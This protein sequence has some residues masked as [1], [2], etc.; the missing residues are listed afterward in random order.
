MRFI[1]CIGLLIYCTQ[2]LAQ[3][4][5]ITLKDT[6]GHPIS[7]A[8]VVLSR[9]EAKKGEKSINK[10]SD[11]N[12]QITYNL[13]GKVVVQ[14][15]HSGFK[16]GVDTVSQKH[17]T[18][19][20]SPLQINLDETV[21]TAQYS[22]EDAKNSLYPVQ[23]INSEKIHQMASNN[24]SEVLAQ[25]LNIRITQDP[26]L[27]SGITLMGLRG[28][29]VKYLVDGV[30]IIGR[31]NGDIDI[32]QVNL[33]DIEKIEVIEGPMS[34]LYGTNAL[35]GVINLITK[36]NQKDLLNI[37]ANAYYESVGTY[38]FDAGLG[39][40]KKNHY[41]GINGGRYFF[42][43]FSLHPD[44]R[45][46]DWN[47]KTQYFANLKYGYQ[48]KRIRFLLSG[49]YFNEKI[50]NKGN[51]RAPF[52]TS[53][54]DD[55][56]KTTRAN[57]ALTVNGDIFKNHYFSQIISYNWYQ[58]K[59]NTYYKDL[60]TL[61][62]TLVGD[63]TQ[64]DTTVFNSIMAR[65][66]VS[67]KADK[68]IFNYQFGYDINVE[69]GSGQRIDNGKKTIGDYAVFGS[70]RA[71]L[72]NHKLIIQPGLRWSYNSA[73]KAPVTPSINFKINPVEHFTIRLAY[74]RGFRAPA[75]KELYFAFYD[76]NH[77]IYGNPDLKAEY[78]NNATINLTYTR[79]FGSHMLNLQANAYFNDI[80]NA[81]ELVRDY[82]NTGGNNTQPYTYQNYANNRVAGGNVK[83][84]YN[85]DEKL[86]VSVSAG[87]IGDNFKYNAQ[88]SSGGFDLT[89]EFAIEANY[90]IPKALVKVS[91][92]NKFNGKTV[93]PY[94]DVNSQVQKE[95]IQPYDLMQVSLGR[96]FWKDRFDIV[97]GA[98]NLLNVKTV[99]TAGGNG[100][101]HSNGENYILVGWGRTFFATVRFNI[102]IKGH[103]NS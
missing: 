89:P 30:P 61:D 41:L 24:L 36:T 11:K 54:F 27:G 49:G 82:S 45:S 51:A 21:V 40:S 65:G 29:Q 86:S 25:Q 33:N 12:G 59:K 26:I 68:G 57:G 85:W 96:K 58:R 72:L 5:S 99:D 75:I 94:I 100:A 64:Q 16:Y 53:A 97:V 93:S 1:L 7:D 69:S 71:T 14:I 90:M 43:G 20:L 103:E 77:D 88:L 81:I 35:G 28:E 18:I 17:A 62:Q 95:T 67:R 8:F 9:V 39:F 22:P 52:N 15:S 44:E 37:N 83:V 48:L 101:A 98:K 73:F 47:P 63:S 78:S 80:K 19:I 42:D 79:S 66:F 6:T 70:A 2:L 10:V 55:Y 34:V 92:Y 4:R 23:I 60:T 91:F 13:T 38:N 32:S 74:A 87:I 31:V 46:Q 3:E 76:V 56:Y 102:S 84:R 50:T